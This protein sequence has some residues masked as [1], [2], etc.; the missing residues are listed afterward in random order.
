MPINNIVST[1]NDPEYIRALENELAALRAEIA[2]LR[3]EVSDMR[4][5]R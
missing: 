5:N 3:S 4:R 2:R 1:L